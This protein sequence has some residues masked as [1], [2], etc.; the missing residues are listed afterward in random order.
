LIL[1]IV[2]VVAYK[3]T[4]SI[5]YV[6]IGASSQTAVLYNLFVH[7]AKHSERGR[8]A[9]AIGIPIA[10]PFIV[11]IILLIMLILCFIRKLEYR[12]IAVPGII[13]GFL[14]GFYM[15]MNIIGPKMLP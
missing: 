15:W 6:P 3:I 12:R 1:S 4:G 8:F 7:G 9:I 5:L 10:I 11:D 2:C 13:F 14:G